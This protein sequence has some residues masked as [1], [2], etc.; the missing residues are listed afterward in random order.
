MGLN[1]GWRRAAR[2]RR[3]RARTRT[4]SCPRATANAVGDTGKAGGGDTG[5]APSPLAWAQHP[6]AG[7]AGCGSR[8]ITRPG[9]MAG[10]G[11]EGTTVV[12]SGGG[13]GRGEPVPGTGVAT[14]GRE[15]RWCLLSAKAKC[16]GI[17][18]AHRAV[19]GRGARPPLY[20][21][22]ACGAVGSAGGA[23]GRQG[24]G[25]PRSLGVW[26]AGDVL[27]PS[28]SESTGQR[29]VL[30]LGVC[31]WSGGGAEFGHEP[32][33]GDVPKLSPCPGSRAA[34]T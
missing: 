14:G 10:G 15:P 16:S 23:A 3:Q 11:S 22:G 29:A 26:L 12:P 32:Y 33:R 24:T 6:S 27:S 17:Y 5:R 31:R 25:T 30:G 18:G 28:L 7:R 20:R 1:A 4:S 34:G 8:G 19:A 2:W 9:D 13:G 21:A